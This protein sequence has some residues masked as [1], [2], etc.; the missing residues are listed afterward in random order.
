MKRMYTKKPRKHFKKN[1]MKKTTK[2]FRKLICAAVGGDGASSSPTAAPPDDEGV[3]QVTLKEEFKVSGIP[4]RVTP[5]PS[6]EDQNKIKKVIYISVPYDNY[7]SEKEE[8]SYKQINYTLGD[9]NYTGWIPKNFTGRSFLYIE[10]NGNTD[11]SNIV[12]KIIDPPEYIHIND[13][14][15]IKLKKE[16]YSLKGFVAKTWSYSTGFYY[17]ETDRINGMR[18]H[19]Y[20]KKDHVTLQSLP[21]ETIS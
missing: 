5:V 20:I 13:G 18:Y 11:K 16:N 8:G 12:K 17:I 19:G 10:P 4:L 21:N 7:E 15:K 9:R 2:K 6:L 14:D 3:K 1:K